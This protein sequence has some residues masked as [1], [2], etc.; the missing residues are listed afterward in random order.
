MKILFKK[1]LKSNFSLSVISLIV[2]LYM[3][4]I[5]YTSRIKYTIPENYNE[6]Y[7]K[8]L[9]NTILVSWHDKIMILPHISPFKLH[10]KLHA[11][12]SP[13]NDGKIISN[14]MKLIGYKIIEGSSNKNSILAVKNIIK[15]LKNGDNVVITPDGPR[16]PRHE[17]K[18][19]LIE[20]AKRT[21]SLIIPFTAKCT[22]FIKLNSWDKLIFPLPF[23]KIEV[24]FGTPV[25]CNT[26]SKIS[27]EELASKLN[28]LG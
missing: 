2:Y 21:E 28:K 10:K 14:T 16:G 12:V 5:H 22:K 17:M 20:I 3:H 19:N 11:L 15:T 27:L 4:L 13:H 24:C 9:K 26:N 18:G 23:G 25:A 7:Y 6:E 8:D 1:F